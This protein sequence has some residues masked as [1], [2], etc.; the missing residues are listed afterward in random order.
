MAEKEKAWDQAAQKGDAWDQAQ[1]S[2]RNETNWAQAGEADQ[3]PAGKQGGSPKEKASVHVSFRGGI[4]VKDENG[5]E[6]HIGRGEIHV[7]SHEGD[8]VHVDRSG[9]IVNGEKK[10][11]NRWYHF[12]FPILAFLLFLGWGF[13]GVFYGWKLSWMSFLTIPL[14]YSL[15][16]AIDQRKPMN[17]AYPVVAVIVFFLWGF[18]G[19]LGGWMT[20]WLIFLTIPLYYTAFEAVKRRK[21]MLFCYPVL[22]AILFFAWGF[23]GMMG[24]FTLAW[25]V[26]LTIPIFYWACGG[27]KE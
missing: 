27:Q 10:R 18:S 23:S 3:G 2:T 17:F 16:S 22:M 12:P 20:S 6:V 8:N 21:P 26:F 25:I 13:S 7:D 24:G 4:H 5:D 15:V 9:V 1:E 19:F 11:L 14:Y